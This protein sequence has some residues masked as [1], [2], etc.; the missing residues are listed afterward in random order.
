MRALRIRGIEASIEHAEGKRL[1]RSLGAIQLTALGIGCIIGAGIFVLTGVGA[2]YAGPALMVSFVIAG[3]ACVFAALTY[4]ELAAMVPVAG[5][6]YTYS[7]ATLGE[8]VAWIVGWNLILEY[9]VAAGAVAAGW[10]G[11]L[12]GILRSQGVD[13]PAELTLSPSD[14]GVF[15]LPAAVIAL[16]VSGLLVLGTGRSSKF[17]I[18][19]VIL[20]LAAVALF[21]V[22]AAPKVD[23]ANWEPF[24]PFGWS[25]V[26]TGAALIFFAYVGFDAVSTAAEETRNPQRDL[27]IGI[28]ASLIICTILYMAVAATATG[29]VSYVDLSAPANRTE[30]LAFALRA[31]GY[32]NWAQLLSV[33]AIIGLTTV[34]LVLIYGQTRIFFAMARDRLLPDWFSQVHERYGTP[35]RVTMITGACVALIAAFFPINEI[36][37]LANIGTLFAFI[38][39]AFGVMILRRTRP[40]VKRAFR[41]PWI[42]FVGP[43]AV[44]SC[45]Y[46]MVSLP[47]L[48]WE[49]FVVWT[50][51][52]ILVYAFYGYRRSPF[53]TANA[54][55]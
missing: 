41:V 19:L 39:V 4:A 14:G 35:H 34:L 38:M 9:T 42:G 46:L 55:S 51:I 24:M 26:A 44:V 30:P 43:A 3:T 54:K 36:A 47:R 11:Y 17:N 48:T 7:Y 28:I 52:G 32:D 21:I 45:G 37:E 53:H 22:L 8:A 10:S 49:R 5:S 16:F 33:G 29:A 31:I 18:L 2:M 15:N 12:V 6:A 50:L 40:D 27:P 20:K 25:G 23:T 13:L 1:V